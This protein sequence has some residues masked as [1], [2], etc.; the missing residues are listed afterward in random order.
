MGGCGQA[1][2][3]ALQR[4]GDP[5]Q[6]LLLSGTVPSPVPPDTMAGQAQ[7]SSAAVRGAVCHT[8]QAP[9]LPHFCRSRGPGEPELT[10]NSSLWWWWA[11]HHQQSTLHLAHSR[12][13]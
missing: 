13:N 2:G 12:G 3:G 5:N 10:G 1:R 4:P 6:E 11:E 9:C 8:A 7:Q